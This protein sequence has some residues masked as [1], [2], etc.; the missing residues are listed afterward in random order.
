VHA[1]L[2]CRIEFWRICTELYA[3]ASLQLGVGKEEE[4]CFDLP[5][6]SED[7]GTK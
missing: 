1:A 5:K 4:D 2:N 7:Y 3:K 6:T